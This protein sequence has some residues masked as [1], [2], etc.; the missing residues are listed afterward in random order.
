MPVANRKRKGPSTAGA[1]AEKTRRS[2][3]EVAEEK[4]IAARLGI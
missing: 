1:K 4:I 3:V 2:E